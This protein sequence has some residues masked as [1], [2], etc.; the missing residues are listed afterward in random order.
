LK[1]N[2]I[3]I[4]KNLDETNF[5]TEYCSTNNINLKAVSFIVT[6]A[7]SS[8]FRK[9]SEVYFFSSKNGFDYF[10]QNNVIE[11]NKKIAC[12]GE[13][14]KKHI[15]K[16]GYIV[17]FYGKNASN[18]NEVVIQLKNW[19]EN[20]RISFILSDISKKSISNHFEE[21]QKEEAVFYLTKFNSIQL[22]EKFD[23][24]IFTSPSNF[25]AFISNNLFSLNS[26]IISWGKTTTQAILNRG[27][28]VDFELKTA[29]MNE[30]IDW[31]KFNL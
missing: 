28:E 26:K 16:Q 9:P 25:E 6:E 15:E 3:L 7:V 30:L 11:V 12:I 21:E 22:H 17:D 29:S 5:L 31:L 23:V 2:K 13:S 4:T 10:I 1:T 27:L 8:V 20:K 19:L 24:Y 18:P 14:T